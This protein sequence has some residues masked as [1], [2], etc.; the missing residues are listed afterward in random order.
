VFFLTLRRLIGRHGI[1]PDRLRM[2]GNIEISDEILAFGGFADLR[3]GTYKGH[4]VAVKTM[5]IAAR[6]DL[7]VIRKVTTDV[8]CPGRGLIHSVLAILQGSRPLE[9]AVPSEHLGTHWSPGG[10]QETAAHHR[11][12]MDG[13]WKYYGIHQQEPRQQAG[14][15]TPLHFPA[16]SITK[17]RWQLHG[18]AQGL[19]YLHGV[20]LVHGDLKGVSVPPFRH[21]SILYV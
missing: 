11:I 16:T 4:L 2:A 18:A 21:R 9:H 3:S 8:N 5:R 13:A 7:Q 10:H 6:D 17:L 15:C 19:K 1:L 20:S 14:T 12:G